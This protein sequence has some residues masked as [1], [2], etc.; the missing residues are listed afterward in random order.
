ML[1][2][3]L[4]RWMHPFFFY[5]NYFY[6]NHEAQISKN[7]LFTFSFYHNAV[8]RNTKPNLKLSRHSLALYRYNTVNICMLFMLIFSKFRW[9]Y[10]DTFLGE[11][12]EN[13]TCPVRYH[14][15]INYFYLVFWPDI[16]KQLPL[17]YS[18]MYLFTL[19]DDFFS[20]YG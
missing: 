2:T 16:R 5:K 7:C 6:R 14:V 9:W 3:S 19:L 4:R 1:S 8:D 13:C 18:K 17:L 15:K 20:F 11:L 10:I 12:H